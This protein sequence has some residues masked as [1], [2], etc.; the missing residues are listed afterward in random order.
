MD[1]REIYKFLDL[2]GISYEITEH[3]VASTWNNW[4]MLIFLIRGQ[5]KKSGLFATRK[6]EILFDNR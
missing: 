2:K 6:R 1:K 5:S 3:Q 4:R